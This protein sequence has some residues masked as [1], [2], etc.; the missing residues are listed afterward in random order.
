MAEKVS[1]L[2][3]DQYVKDVTAEIANCVQTSACQPIL[4]IGSGVS[5]R[6]FGG[7]SWDELLAHVASACPLI[8]KQYAYYKQALGSPLAIG[9]EFA[10]KYH[11]W[12]WSGGKNQFP[13]ELFDD[14]VPANAYIKYKVAEYLTSITPKAVWPAPGLDDT[15]L[16]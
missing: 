5:K 14:Q 16:S 6:Y 13:A 2:K 15:C 3:Y 8:D 12:A 11:E 9:E 10:S 1:S 7:P 4:F